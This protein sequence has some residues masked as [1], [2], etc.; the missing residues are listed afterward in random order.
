MQHQVRRIVLVK[1]KITMYVHIEPL[2]ELMVSGTEIPMME[3]RHDLNI[4]HTQKKVLRAGRF[5]PTMR[6]L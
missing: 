3:I 1:M 2:E 6:Q 4:I 5:G